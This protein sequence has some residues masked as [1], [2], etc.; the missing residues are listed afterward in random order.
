MVPIGFPVD[1]TPRKLASQIRAVA[2]QRRLREGGDPSQALF[3]RQKLDSRLRGNDA[4]ERR[5]PAAA[6]HAPRFAPCIEARLFTCTSTLIVSIRAGMTAH[7][8]QA[9]IHL[10]VPQAEH[11]RGGI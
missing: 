7:N 11:L 4:A 5:L 6:R 1:M 8:A 2:P 10:R 3:Q 9:G